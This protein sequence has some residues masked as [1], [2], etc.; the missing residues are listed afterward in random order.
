MQLSLVLSFMD[1]LGGYRGC[2]AF[3]KIDKQFSIKNL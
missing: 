1:Y 3:V 2:E